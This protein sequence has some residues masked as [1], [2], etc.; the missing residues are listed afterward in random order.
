MHE[1]FMMKLQLKNLINQESC[2]LLTGNL[3]VWERKVFKDI[4]WKQNS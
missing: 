3:I 4:A 2:I 1:S